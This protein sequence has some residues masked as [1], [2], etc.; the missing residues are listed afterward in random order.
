MLTMEL[1]GMPSHAFQVR[2]VKPRK[3]NQK[4]LRNVKAFFEHTEAPQTLRR[5]SLA[6]QLT[7]GVEAMVSEIPAAG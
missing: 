4:R 7:G 2:S 1:I 5:T 6:F 3:E